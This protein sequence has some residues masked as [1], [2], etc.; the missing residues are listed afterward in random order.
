[1]ALCWGGASCP[2]T[3]L[4]QGTGPGEWHELSKRAEAESCPEPQGYP[5]TPGFHLGRSNIFSM[6][7]VYFV[8]FSTSCAGIWALWSLGREEGGPGSRGA[9]PQ[10][11]S[12]PRLPPLMAASLG[13]W[14]LWGWSRSS[15][16]SPVGP[17]TASEAW[18]AQ[19]WSTRASRASGLSG[20]PLQ[21]PVGRMW[22]QAAAKRELMGLGLCDLPEELVALKACRAPRLRVLVLSKSDCPAGWSEP[23]TLPCLAHIQHGRCGKARWTRALSASDSWEARL[24]G[25]GGEQKHGQVS[26]EESAL[27]LWTQWTWHSGLPS[28]QLSTWAWVLPITVPPLAF[29]GAPREI[30]IRSLPG[31][32]PRVRGGRVR[33]AGARSGGAGGE[34][35]GSGPGS[36]VLKVRQKGALRLASTEVGAAYH[37]SA[38]PAESSGWR[39]LTPLLES[40]RLFTHAQVLVSQ[41]SSIPGPTSSTH[42]SMM[43]GPEALEPK[44]GDQGACGVGSL[45]SRCWARV[46]PPP[47]QPRDS[48]LPCPPF[49]TQVLLPLPPEASPPGEGAAGPKPAGAPPCR[50]TSVSH[51]RRL[52]P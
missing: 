38:G 18:G 42:R 2:W 37:S 40:V 27:S 41:P 4:A 47:W 33:G 10:A 43:V 34:V 3:G 28:A 29:H 32:Q 14:L 22:D 15:H 30:T 35:R 48:V 45:C 12:C 44:H 50:A 9:S 52:V 21:A 51:P 39:G 13:S 49:L 36:G 31:P 19:S 25:G 26:R 20:K 46:L 16:L 24:R 7:G 23:S 11:P 6:P 1:M 17:P 5:V 8:R